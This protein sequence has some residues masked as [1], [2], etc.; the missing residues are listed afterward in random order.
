MLTRMAMDRQVILAAVL[1][2]G[3]ALAHAETRT[4]VFAGGCFWCV[5]ALYQE[6]EGVIDAVSGFTGGTHPNPTYSGAHTGHYEAVLVTYDPAVIDYS[7]LL[8]LF[9]LNVDPVDAR[10]Q[11]CDKGESYRSAIFVTPEQRS[12][13]EASLVQVV[14]Q[15]DEP[16]ATRVLPVAKFFP[17]EKYHQDYYLKNPIRY[18]FYRTSCRRDARLREVWAERS[19]P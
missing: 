8:T 11:F 16:V 18:K 1:L 12:L 5:E 4:A 9:W 6:T 13:A 17:V 2:L 7:R 14:A 15:F 19:A 10:G 3:T